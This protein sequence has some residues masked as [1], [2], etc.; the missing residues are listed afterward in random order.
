M[1]LPIEQKRAYQLN[2]VRRN[3]AEW[4]QENG[5]CVFCGSTEKLEID[6]IDP[7]DK[8]SH[9]IWSYSK[10]KRLTE[11]AKCRVLCRACHIE[12]HRQERIQHGTVTRRKAGCRCQPCNEA[13]RGYLLKLHGQ[14]VLVKRSSWR[15]DV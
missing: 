11:L 8:F 3:R 6:H 12:R 15:N 10:E 14:K 13:W 2:L 5:P 7:S 1:P 4:L 9:R